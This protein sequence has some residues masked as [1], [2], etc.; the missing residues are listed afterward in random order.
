MMKTQSNSTKVRR[1]LTIAI[2]IVLL[3][4][5]VLSLTP[6]TVSAT[7]VGSY[8]FKV[9]SPA[10]ANSKI[11]VTAKDQAGNTY[12]TTFTLG[13]QDEEQLRNTV[14]TSLQGDGWVVTKNGKNG[15]DITYGPLTPALRQTAIKQVDIGD[16]SVWITT[17]T[18]GNVTGGWADPGKKKFK[19]IA[20]LP[21]A[22]STAPGTLVLALNDL[23]VSVP[24]SPGDSP[25]D[26]A[27]KLEAELTNAD[28]VV[29]RSGSEVTLDWEDPANES[30][31]TSPLD[32]WF[33]LED[34]AGGP[35]ITLEFPDVATIPTLTEWG[36]IIFCV[37]LFGWMAWV[38]VRRRRRV[39]VGI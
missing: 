35:H 21:N 15:I 9:K 30:M 22:D 3:S 7:N 13:G 5:V 4:A 37:L 39:T 24:L 1:L 8:T 20:A 36:M 18:D 19:F 31:L 10:S 28:L 27:A 34:G 2:A 29:T 17:N 11:R 23:T 26:A 12:D 6:C 16:N 33:G 38:V 25:T 32:L 14:F